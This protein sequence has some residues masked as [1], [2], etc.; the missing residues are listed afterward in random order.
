MSRFENL[1]TKTPAPGVP[2]IP[3]DEHNP[4]VNGFAMPQ[5]V[6]Q[7]ED[8]Q[9]LTDM[10]RPTSSEMALRRLAK[11]AG[12][13]PRVAIGGT[14]D[15]ADNQAPAVVRAPTG[16]PVAE[17]GLPIFAATLNS[18]P[19][20]LPRRTRVSAPAG[21]TQNTAPGVVSPE[22][23]KQPL[24]LP[25]ASASEISLYNDSIN[26]ENDQGLRNW[27][28]DQHCFIRADRMG[29]IAEQLASVTDFATLE[30]ARAAT[31]DPE[32]RRLIAKREYELFNQQDGI[33]APISPIERLQ[34]MLAAT[35]PQAKLEIAYEMNKL[36]LQENEVTPN[37][38]AFTDNTDEVHNE[39]VTLLER[40]V[41]GLRGL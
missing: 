34:A 27:A 25:S 12:L 11:I 19:P 8:V 41:L 20:S 38:G 31:N 2:I 37:L 16:S 7:F 32:T 26:P 3:A 24:V 30:S 1:D 13:Q 5:H 14:Q 21:T 23:P 29:Y 40:V 28:W 22:Q 35:D 39:R 4:L 10:D 15:G 6:P 33:I 9:S 36:R 17:V 18:P